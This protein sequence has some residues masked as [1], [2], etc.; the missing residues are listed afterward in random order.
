MAMDDSANLATRL[1]KNDE[2]I[3]NAD[4]LSV[5]ST[6]HPKVQ[7][8]DES[9]DL[10]SHMGL[11]TSSRLEALPPELRSKIISLADLPTLRCL[12]RAS[13]I[14][15]AQYHHCRH[16]ILSNCLVRELDGFWID[17][18]ACVKSRVSEI[19]S[20]RTD[21]KVTD[22]L[23][24]Y[25][26]QLSG[27]IQCPDID[28]I[29]PGVVRWMAAFYLSVARPLACQ[30]S[31][32]AL[33]NLGKAAS[34]SRP[35]KQKSMNLATAELVAAGNP[36]IELSRSEKIRVFRAL[37]RYQIYHHLFGRN[38]V[39]R[40]GGFRHHEIADIFFGLFD[41]WE[42]EAVGCIDLFVRDKYEDLFNKVKWDL[43]LR[44]P[45]FLQP[46]GV[47]NPEGSFDLTAEHDSKGNMGSST[48]RPIPE[49]SIPLTSTGTLD[50]MDGTVSRGLK[51]TV[52]LL[53]VDDHEK[54]VIKMKRCLTYDQN[55][56]APMRRALC[57]VAQVDRREMSTNFPNAADKA[58]QRRAPIEFTGDAVPVTADTPPWAWVV[59]WGGK[60]A[61]V[62]GEYVPELLRRC[63]Y[64]MWDK[65]RWVDSRAEDFLGEQWTVNPE[66][67][68]EIENDY[69]WRPVEH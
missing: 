35:I 9:T 61:N 18:L 20:P 62:F 12:V 19:L 68:K 41:P 47:A 54:L 1:V 38:K 23:V 67:V 33:A 65:L 15:H 22:F 44:N 69:D 6:H 13:P 66:L 42:A 10:S 8:E 11:S 55:K 5:N 36:D 24:T 25:G 34:P 63:A 31:T 37:Y 14:L 2:V 43:D 3:K 58:E 45:R 48:L 29:H 46:N 39:T 53:A 64:V 59:L 57:M 40:W 30:Y 52:R 28:L 50:Y 16:S 26:H 21:E 7:G 4:D 17:S 56:D 51:M 49:T 60:Y 27:S 32:W